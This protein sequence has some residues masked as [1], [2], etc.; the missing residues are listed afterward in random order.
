MAFALVLDHYGLVGFP[1]RAM[2]PGRAMGA[3]LLVV[4]VVLIRKC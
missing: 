2:S 3:G 4:G 1:V